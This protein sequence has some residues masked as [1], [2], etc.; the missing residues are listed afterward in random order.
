M[1]MNFII[2]LVDDDED[3]RQI[4]TEAVKILKLPAQI[5]Q[6]TNGV[7][8]LSL[9]SDPSVPAPEIMVFDFNMPRMNGLELLRAVRAKS[10]HKKTPIVMYSTSSRPEDINQCLKSGADA[11]LSKHSSFTQVCKDLL[12]VFRQYIS[13]DMMGEESD[14]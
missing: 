3:D 6:A 8:A 10:A 14:L 7:Q 11:Y 1:E 13:G 4:F 5:I 2:L 9:I 12:S